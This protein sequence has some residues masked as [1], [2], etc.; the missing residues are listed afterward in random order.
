MYPFS[1]DFRVKFPEISR[2]FQKFFPGK[3]EMIFSGIPGISR[4]GIPGKSA[5]IYT[6]LV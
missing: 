5:L 3:R 1:L 6:E 2:E 4:A